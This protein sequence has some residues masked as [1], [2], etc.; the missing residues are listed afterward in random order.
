[1]ISTLRRLLM[2]VAVCILVSASSAVAL[3]DTLETSP[4]EALKALYDD[5]EDL[6]AT[7]DQA[8]VHMK[9][10]D[11]ETADL[12]P[13]PTDVNPWKGKEFDDLVL[14]FDEWYHLLPTPSG[15]QDEF[16]VTTQP[17]SAD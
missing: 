11:P 2:S 5:N 6:H 1:M 14:F 17:G 12:W 7:M 13:N 3:Q 10:P 15:A 16:N 9:D 4:I 8:F